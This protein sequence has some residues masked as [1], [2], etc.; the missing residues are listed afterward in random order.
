MIKRCNAASHHSSKAYTPHTQDMASM[1]LRHNPASL[2][3]TQEHTQARP[4]P[5]QHRVQGQLACSR[6]HMHTPK[7]RLM[8]CWALRLRSILL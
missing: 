3:N 2:C 4:K 6:P 8:L 5:R 7:V 1:E